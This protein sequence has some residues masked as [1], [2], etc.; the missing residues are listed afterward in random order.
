MSNKLVKSKKKNTVSKYNGIDKNKKSIIVCL[1]VSFVIS[2]LLSGIY[3]N[4]NYIYKYQS[5]WYE[6]SITDCKGYNIEGTVYN[7]DENASEHYI[8]FSVPEVPIKT[9]N[10]QLNAAPGDTIE[11]EADMLKDGKSLGKID[12]NIPGH[13]QYAKLYFENRKINSVR[14]YLKGTFDYNSANV[15]SFQVNED[16][17]W[18]SELKHR[19]FKVFLIMFIIFYI[20]LKRKLNHSKGI[21]LYDGNSSKITGIVSQNKGIIISEIL[22]Y[23]IT[24]FGVLGLFE[25]GMKKSNYRNMYVFI[26]LCVWIIISTI[27]W[28]IKNNKIKFEKMF[29]I[30]GSMLSC[31]FIVLLPNRLNISYDDQI[32][33]KNIVALSHYPDKSVSVAEDDYYLSCFVPQLKNSCDVKDKSYHNIIN[34]SYSK[35]TSVGYNEN[36]T[37]KS[38]V[39]MPVAIAMMILRGIGLNL[40][41]IILGAKLAG[42]LFYLY[43]VYRGMKHLKNGKM[44]VAAAST[45]PGAMFIIANF[46]YDY[47]LIGL[48]LYS[49]C[50]I[51]GEYQNPDKYIKIKDFVYIIAST[52]LGIAVKVV[53]IPLLGII[54]FLPKKKFEKKKGIVA[55]RCFFCGIVICAIIGFA[56]LIFGGGL[57]IGDTRGGEEINAMGQ[58][59]YILS[60]PLQYTKTLLTFIK[61]YWSIKKIPDYNTATAYLMKPAGYWGYVAAFMLL[62]MLYDRSDNNTVKWYLSASSILIGFITSCMVATALYV[63]YNPVGSLSIVGCQARY[64]FPIIVSGMLVV[65]RIYIPIKLQSSIIKRAEEIITILF[66]I[67]L[68]CCMLRTML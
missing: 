22:C 39:Y 3:F 61:D 56:I 8:D 48:T 51:V 47:W 27:Y 2:L 63:V 14:V 31:M 37:Y 62:V 9:L 52:L 21:G 24:F 46:N 36:I 13:E 6:A 28:Y 60:N 26:S 7:Y 38:V 64:L 33:Y 30:V 59:K 45:M 49:T 10:I 18:L 65:S 40:S 1:V 44:V 55:F 16:M 5:I 4:S 17:S 58:I 32:H 42:V 25:I 43:I 19:T 50:Y 67:V 23:V 15:Q 68:N 66:I 29:L 12:S 54:A 34:D 11:L 41:L 57:G 20:L 35:R 53:Y